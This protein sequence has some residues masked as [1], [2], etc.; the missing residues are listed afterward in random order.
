MKK[1]VLTCLFTLLP[2]SALAGPN[3]CEW[4]GM[5]TWVFSSG[6]T[7]YTVACNATNSQGAA[8]Q[9][10]AEAQCQTAWDNFAHN[11]SDS[12]YFDVNMSL[13]TVAWD[14]SLRRWHYS[15][16]TCI[17]GYPPAFAD[18][19][20]ERVSLVV[21]HENAVDKVAGV[22]MGIEFYIAKDGDK[23]HYLVDVWGAKGMVQV[24]VDGATGVASVPP[25]DQEDDAICVA[26]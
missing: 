25:S 24:R 8:A 2:L 5:N 15:C 14:P 18:H 3:T 13:A 16:R 4:N 10:Y 19:E 26:R 17:D 11:Y 7:P 1:T 21:A 9:A 20:L 6:A 22:V 23:A 12:G